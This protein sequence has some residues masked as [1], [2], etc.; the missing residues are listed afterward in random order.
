MHQA[1]GHNGAP[2][3]ADQAA[4]GPP[5]H[6]LEIAQATR[7]HQE[8]RAMAG[9][10]LARWERTWVARVPAGD[11]IAMAEGLAARLRPQLELER[12]GAKAPRGGR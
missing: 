2:E 12:R 9:E 5:A 4:A 6:V 10:E 3:S 11:L 8:Q 7:R 1:T